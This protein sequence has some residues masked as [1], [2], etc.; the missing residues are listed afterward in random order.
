VAPVAANPHLASATLTSP[1]MPPT[2][3]TVVRR[4]GRG[5]I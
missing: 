3:L 2:I 5:Q 1:T 4:L